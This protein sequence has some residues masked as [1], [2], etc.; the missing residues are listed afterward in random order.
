MEWLIGN[1]PP[2]MLKIGIILNYKTAEKKKDEL[3]NVNSRKMKWLSLGNQDKY[4]KF[5]II[6]N[7][8]KFVPAD[9]AIGLYLEYNHPEVIIDYITPE[10][11]STKR[12]KSNDINFVIIYDL[13]ESFHL[14]DK[15]N[16]HNYKRA[17]KNSNNVYQNL[18]GK[19]I[20]DNDNTIYKN[21]YY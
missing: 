13:L 19:W 9:V 1:I 7:K 15:S 4:K 14:S 6:S 17:L 20:I 11:I 18:K 21:L 3:L 16:F 8:K 12:F 10:E 5:V 2:K